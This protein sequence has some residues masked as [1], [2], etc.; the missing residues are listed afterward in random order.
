MILNY[1]NIMGRGVK[2]ETQKNETDILDKVNHYQ[3]DKE[4]ADQFF[5]K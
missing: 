2:A 4:W 1:G 3:S 5:Q